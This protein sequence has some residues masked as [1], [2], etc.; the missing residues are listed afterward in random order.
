MKKTYKKFKIRKYQNADFDKVLDLFYNTIHSV[1]IHDYTP[2]QID[3]WANKE[4]K[5]D[6]FKKI[7]IENHTLVIEDLISKNEILGFADL[8][9]KGYLNCFYISKDFQKVGL[10]KALIQEIFKLAFLLD[11]KVIITESSITAKGFF[12]NAGFECISAQTR[13][14][15]S[16]EFTNYIMRK[17]LDEN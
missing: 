15:N 11:I 4:T 16:V 14:I 17:V 3:I 2:E 7:F 1:N 9:N 12:E 5:I 10:G 13:T 6:K 8:S